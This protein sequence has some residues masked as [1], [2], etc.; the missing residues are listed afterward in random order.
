[1]ALRIEKEHTRKTGTL[2]YMSCITRRK[3]RRRAMLGPGPASQRPPSCN[4]NSSSNSRTNNI[5]L[6]QTQAPRAIISFNFCFRLKPASLR[7]PA[8][9]PSVAYLSVSA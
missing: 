3:L 6:I 9:F 2:S 4:S 5:K 7:V 1:M 8:V